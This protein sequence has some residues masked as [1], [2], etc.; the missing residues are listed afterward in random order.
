MK[1]WGF[2]SLRFYSLVN[3]LTYPGGGI[4]CGALASRSV[5]NATIAILIHESA[6]ISRSG[7]V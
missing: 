7:L 1:R 4:L 5:R 2:L 3:G 6:L